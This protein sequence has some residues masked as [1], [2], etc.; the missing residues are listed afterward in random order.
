MST[1][2][3]TRPHV[4]TR[5]T[6]ITVVLAK[7]EAR[8]YFRHPVFLLSL[9]PLPVLLGVAANAT[10][11][12]PLYVTLVSS[13]FIGVGGFV[14]AHRLTTSMHGSTDLL[15]TT[16][17]RQVTRTGALCCACV[18]PVLAS[19]VWLAT[20]AA[21]LAV[22]PPQGGTPNSPVAWFG[23]QRALDMLAVLAAGGPLTAAGGALLG[24]A[25][26]RWAPFRGSLVVGVALL[27]VGV[28]M[29]TALPLP[30]MAASPFVLF[31]DEVVVNGTIVAASLIDGLAP[32]W[33]AVYLTCL[34]ALAAL[35]ALLHDAADRS[36][37]L[38]LSAAF[39]AAG[40]GALAIAVS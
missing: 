19:I 15:A 17:V 36:R 7:V 40:A 8:R 20:S 37:L 29:M 26:A 28:D 38:A 12:D 10:N 16:P 25:V 23:D 2:I 22:R 13:L 4:T 32:L 34:C 14:V 5:Q 31:G 6:P 33:Y 3:G 1:A 9:L 21:W 35:A 11:A 18:V 39:V 30:W 24:V 27:V